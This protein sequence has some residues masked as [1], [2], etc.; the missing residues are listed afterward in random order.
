MSLVTH[1]NRL[2]VKFIF[3]LHLITLP[4]TRFGP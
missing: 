2:L 3:I 4:Y 1:L